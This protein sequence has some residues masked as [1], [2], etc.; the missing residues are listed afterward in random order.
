[1][2]HAEPVKAIPDSDLV[3][4]SGPLALI[5]LRGGV[6]HFHVGEFFL[7]NCADGVG[8]C[9]ER[10]NGQQTGPVDSESTVGWVFLVAPPVCN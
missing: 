6:G 5:L 1:M 4:V 3:L 9:E 2:V 10:S 8:I 7:A